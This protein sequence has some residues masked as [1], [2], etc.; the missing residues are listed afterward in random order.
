MLLGWPGKN[1]VSCSI[2]ASA[3]LFASSRFSEYLSYPPSL[4]SFATILLYTHVLSVSLVALEVQ[5]PV[6]R[7]LFS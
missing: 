5:G 3:G 4:S 1:F 6:S 2:I 7:A